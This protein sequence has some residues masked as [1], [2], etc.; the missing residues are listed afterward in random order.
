M[1]NRLSKPTKRSSRHHI[2]Y[3]SYKTVNTTVYP[4]AAFA[5]LGALDVHDFIFRLLRMRRTVVQKLHSARHNYY[6]N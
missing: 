4:H 6:N 3:Y 1:K 5:G 2:R